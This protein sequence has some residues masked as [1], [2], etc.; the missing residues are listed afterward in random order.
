MHG[1][2]T[3]ALKRIYYIVGE[4]ASTMRRRALQTISALS[5]SDG[6]AGFRFYTLGRHQDACR[7]ARLI[8]TN[9]GWV[10]RVL[11]EIGMC[12]VLTSG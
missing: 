11:S 1:A 10:P 6:R 3:Q 12:F 7:N 5:G 8:T 4:L 2:S 9:C